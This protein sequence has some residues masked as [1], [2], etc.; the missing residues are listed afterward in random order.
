MECKEKQKTH[1]DQLGIHGNQTMCSFRIALTAQSNSWPCRDT[2]HCEW[3]VHSHKTVFK[4]ALRQIVNSLLYHLSWLKHRIISY[5][6]TMF[7]CQEKKAPV[8]PIPVENMGVKS[9]L[10]PR[11]ILISICR[12]SHAGK[13]GQE[14]SWAPMSVS[15]G[16]CCTESGRL[17]ALSC[18]PSIF[19]DSLLLW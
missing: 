5:V 7:W 1:K 9:K 2:T 8:P 17:D 16:S 14:K 6:E 18:N 12:K 13:A 19:L 3:K 11:H 10:P 15:S 4:C